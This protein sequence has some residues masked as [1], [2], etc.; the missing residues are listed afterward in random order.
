MK[1]ERKYRE[2]YRDLVFPYLSGN[3]EK[4]YIYWMPPKYQDVDNMDYKVCIDGYYQICLGADGWFYRCTSAAASNFKACR[5][6]RATDDIN[7]FEDIICKNQDQE[8]SPSTCF[9]LKTRCSRMALDI[10]SRWNDK[11]V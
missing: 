6:G 4:P 1:V 7:K 5:L 11:N 9:D 2:K 8:W 10:N 3:N